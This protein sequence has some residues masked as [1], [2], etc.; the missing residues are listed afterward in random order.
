M[1]CLYKIYSNYDGFTPRQIPQR[2]EDGKL[3]LGWKHYID[4]VERG[5]EC[6]VYFHGRHAFTD[7]VYVRGFVDA[8]D[9]EEKFVSLRVRAY[10]IEEPLTDSATSERIAR[11]VSPRYRQVFLWPEEWSLAPEC[12]LS[13]CRER[14]CADCQTW[15]E[16]PLINPAHRNEPERLR[17]SQ[18]EQLVQGHWIVPNRCYY[19]EGEMAAGVRLVTDRFYNFKLGEMAYAYPFARTIFEQLTQAE[20]LEFDYVVPIPLSPDKMEDGEAHRTLRLAEELGELLVVPVREILKLESNVSKRRM[21]SAGYTARQFERA[22]RSALHVEIPDD[23]QKLLLVDDVMTRGSTVA[24][25]LERLYESQSPLS[26][27]VATA[28]QMI[29]KPVVVDEA[30]FRE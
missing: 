16:L 15:I 20:Q 26:V 2:M 11:T 3:R 22:Y 4:T 8:I 30:G 10:N 19:D 5:W 14:A 24:M 13:A 23:A 1:R 29:V 7:G 21:S 9:L 12:R 28:G 25:A 18:Y 6:W 27:V 17:W